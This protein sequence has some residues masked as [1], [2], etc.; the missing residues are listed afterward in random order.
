MT[1]FHPSEIEIK[2]EIRNELEIVHSMKI[3]FP[4]YCHDIIHYRQLPFFPRT[5]RK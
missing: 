3:M 2:N 5:F 4:V 1:V